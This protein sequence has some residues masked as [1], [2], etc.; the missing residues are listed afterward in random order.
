MLA[1]ELQLAQI[2]EKL[3][4]LVDVAATR[5]SDRRGVESGGAARGGI[6][7]SGGFEPRGATVRVWSGTGDEDY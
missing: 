2:G 4:H 1:L 3:Q 6:V 5:R 7:V